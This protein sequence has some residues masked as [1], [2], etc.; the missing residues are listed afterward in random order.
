MVWLDKLA[1][2]ARAPYLNCY[3]SYDHFEGVAYK[4]P[5]G[6]G[7]KHGSWVFKEVFTRLF[8]DRFFLLDIVDDFYCA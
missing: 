7:F 4:P 3:G 5:R 6:G 1:R 8:L 2:T